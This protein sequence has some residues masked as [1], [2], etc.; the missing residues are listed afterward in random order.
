M[1]LIHRLIFWECNSVIININ[2]INNINNNVTSNQ[3][4]LLVELK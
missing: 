3:K 2:V 4:N 1:P